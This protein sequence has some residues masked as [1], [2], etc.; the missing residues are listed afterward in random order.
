MPAPV[1]IIATAAAVCHAVNVRS[2]NFSFKLVLWATLV[3]F[4]YGSQLQI[5]TA[6][7][8]CVGRL[9]LHA[10]F[11]PYRETMNNVFDYVTLI[12][13]ALFGLGGIML[14][15]LETAKNFAKYKRDD[16]R[17]ATSEYAISVVEMALNILV[18]IVFVVFSVF[19]LHSLWSKRVMIWHTIS[20]TFQNIRGGIGKSCI[21][22]MCPACCGE[23]RVNARR[24][25]PSPASLPSSTSPA[26][27]DVAVEMTACTMNM[28]PLYGRQHSSQIDRSLGGRPG[29]Q[30]R[31]WS[32]TQEKR[33]E[34]HGVLARGGAA[35]NAMHRGDSMYL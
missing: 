7:L 26:E 14:Q 27:M 11:E 2:I 8:L 13:T 34:A 24:L 17:A 28:N 32:L 22:R 5:G 18:G 6:L 4:S 21:G 20:A 29:G 1:A 35:Q 25:D 33:D 30:M 3:F 15:S 19:W 16:T 31:S 12:I 10:Q 9:A 23:R